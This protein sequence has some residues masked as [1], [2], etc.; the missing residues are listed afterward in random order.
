MIPF[1]FVVCL[2]LFLDVILNLLSSLSFLFVHQLLS[3][4]LY[5]FDDEKTVVCPREECGKVL[6]EMKRP[7]QIVFVDILQRLRRMYAVPL[8]A[9][10]LHYAAE[11]DE[12]TTTYKNDIWDRNPRLRNMPREERR[13]NLVFAFTAD[14]SETKKEYSTKPYVVTLYTAHP[15]L[16]LRYICFCLN[17]MFVSCLSSDYFVSLYILDI[18]NIVHLQ[19]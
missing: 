15:V 2:S 5:V 16:R 6:A 13:S 3:T 10:Y 1:A 7:R 18:L 11:R 9:K 12:V 19:I 8:L 17:D 4:G 14:S